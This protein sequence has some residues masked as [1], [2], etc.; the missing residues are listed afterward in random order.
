M[1]LWIFARPIAAISRDLD[2]AID[3]LPRFQTRNE[4]GFVVA[5][6]FVA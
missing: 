3:L 6:H 1:R 4:V 5:K 2:K